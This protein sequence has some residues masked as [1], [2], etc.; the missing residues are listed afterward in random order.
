MVELSGSKPKYLCIGR[1]EM[2]Y[3]LLNG[4][5]K[6]LCKNIGHII[7]VCIVPHKRHSNIACSGEHLCSHRK[8]LVSRSEAPVDEVS[9]IGLVPKKLY[10]KSVFRTSIQ[11]SLD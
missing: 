7:K 6:T 3:L 10:W 5:R 8:R 11:E 2:S 1:A 4:S 9:S